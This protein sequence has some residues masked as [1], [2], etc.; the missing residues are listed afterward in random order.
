MSY[1]SVHKS[2]DGPR[3]TV[4]EVSIS[5]DNGAIEPT[6]ILDPSKN[7]VD[8]LTP[9][10]KYRI[11]YINYV[12]HRDMHVDLW[13][14][15]DGEEEHKLVRHLEGRGFLDTQSRGGLTNTG[16]ENKTG[17][18]LLSAYGWKEGMPLTGS[19][20]IEAIKQ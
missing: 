15:V 4:I 10:T 11:D 18:I 16:G 6:V 12:L 5:L 7:Y 3:N 1:L 9:T 13:W 19:L 14:E 2:V 8:P 17:S 20:T